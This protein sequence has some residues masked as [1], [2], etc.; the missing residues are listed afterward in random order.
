[1]GPQRGEEG[2]KEEWKER[3]KERRGR[4]GGGGER[5]KVGGKIEGMIGSGEE[6]K[7][8]IADGGD[9]RRGEGARG[10]KNGGGNKRKRR[11]RGAVICY[12][13]LTRR[14]RRRS[15]SPVVMLNVWRLVQTALQTVRRSVSVFEELGQYRQKELLAN[16]AA[17]FNGFLDQMNN[18]RFKTKCRSSRLKR[19]KPYNEIF[20]FSDFSG[21]FWKREW[22]V[23]VIKG[24]SFSSL[25]SGD[26]RPNIGGKE[27]GLSKCCPFLSHLI[28]RKSKIRQAL[29]VH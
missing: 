20:R 25:W 8:N 10:K 1:M 14:Q 5:S 29:C 16:I 3:G 7:K 18:R 2:G 22:K 13:E 4:K 27:T 21:W 15:A 17:S 24:C 9:G 12:R 23:K 11:R 6:G 26:H 28:C 19:W